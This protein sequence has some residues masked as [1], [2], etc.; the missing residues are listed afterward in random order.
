MY[1]NK[2][3]LLQVAFYMYR[4]PKPCLRWN[5]PVYGISLG[6]S[7][8]MHKQYLYICTVYMNVYIYKYMRKY[9]L[10]AKRGH[11]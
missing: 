3:E 11:V 2:Y 7:E 4:D 8:D 5:S 6:V 9:M 10:F 1:T